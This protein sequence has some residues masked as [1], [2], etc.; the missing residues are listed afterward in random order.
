MKSKEKIYSPL[1]R[2]LHWA[3]AVLMI[4]LFITGFLRMYWM[5]KKTVIAAIEQNMTGVDFTSDQAKQTAK[6]ILKPMWQWHEYAAYVLFAILALRI[7]YMLAKGIRF[8]NPFKSHLSL[9]ERLQGMIYLL[10]Y[11]FVFISAITGAYLK[12][13]EGDLKEPLETI[14]KW[15]VYWFPIFILFH[16]AGIWIAEKG[17]QKGIASKMI[18]GE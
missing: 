13:I 6:A 2:G 3:L 12:W 10:F 9:K 8:P 11:L 4:V 15:A 16:F 14:H 5:G 1:H 17:E 18:G 7:I